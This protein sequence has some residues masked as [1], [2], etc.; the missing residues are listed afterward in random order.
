MIGEPAPC[1]G[2]QVRLDVVA[3][4]PITTLDAREERLRDQVR[5]VVADLGPEEPRDARPVPGHELLAGG[6]VTATPG[7]EKLEVGPHTRI[8]GA[9]RDLVDE[10]LQ[11]KVKATLFGGDHAPKLGRLVLLDRIGSGAMG[12]VFAAYDPRLDRKVAV[13]IVRTGGPEANSRVIAEARALGK[14][15]HPNVV[16]IHDA[17]E[18]DDAI[19]IVMELAP[20]VSLRTWCSSGRDWRDVVRVLGEAAAGIAAAHRAGLIHRDIKPDNI[21]VG[22]DRTRVVDFGLAHDRAGG[23]D[24]T[25]AG[26]PS[27]MAPEQL[28]D[29]PATEASDQFAFGVTLF[30][31][32]YGVRPHGGATRDELRLTARSAY[33]ARPSDAARSARAARTSGATVDGA[34]ATAPAN[35][36]PAPI[37]D[38]PSER[39]RATTPAPPTDGSARAV[40]SS[41]PSWINDLVVRALSPAPSDRFPSMD[42]L[43]SALGRDRRRQRMITLGAV[44]ALAGAAIGVGAYRSQAGGDPCTGG[45]ERRAVVWNPPTAAAVR[46]ALGDAPWSARAFATLEARATSWEGSYRRVCEAS[47]VT[48]AQSDTLLD[49]RMRCLDRALDRLGALST[50]IA[51]PLDSATPSTTLP[52]TT[53]TDHA[54]P[55]PTNGAA[56]STPSSLTLTAATRVDAVSAIHELPDP[57]ACESL[58]DAA[59]LAL[60]TDPAK[61]ARVTEA[62]REIDRAWAAYA[63]GRYQAA[64]TQVLAIE[65]RTADLEA[66]P[67]RAAILLLGA[68]VE[69]RIGAPVAARERLDRALTAAAAAHTPAIELDVW[70]RLLRHE[71]FVGNAGRV[72]E[73]DAFAHAAAA[74]AGRDGGELDGIVGEAH[75]DAGQ[76]DAARKRL[77]RAL[78]S[79]DPLRDDQR[80]LIEMNVGSLELAAGD[81]GAAETALTRAFDL[82]RG[83]LGDGHPTLALYLDKLASVD[84]ARGRIRAALARHDESLALRTAAYGAE[85]R[86]IATSLLQRSRTRIE[87]GQLA[88]AREDLE[89]ARR[90]RAEAYGKA[91]QRLGEIDAARG[92]AA[93]AA[94]D[95]VTARTE[96]DQATTLDP[97]LELAARRRAAGADIPLGQLPTTLDP[98][99]IDR[100]GALAVRVAALPVADAGPLAAALLVRWQ[101]LGAAGHP[102]LALAIA[103]ALAS[104]GNTG[105]ASAMLEAAL[106]GLGDEPSWTRLRLLR[107]LGRTTDAT[108]VAA[109]LPELR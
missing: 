21:L 80:A 99:S 31:A 62:E 86:S 8:V 3:F 10:L 59:E 1:D 61:R 76:L 44:A 109:Q 50:A 88:K 85:D 101:R 26:T 14:L 90:I 39:R 98:F 11:A 37:V 89:T 56:P 6:A 48:G 87:G 54:A 52:A 24:T 66:P 70:A 47:R 27:Y 75:R 78:A 53:A 23:E 95:L 74:R 102:A 32:L 4:D 18:I 77:Q 73:W 91:S 5:T 58:H 65:Q 46:T 19:Y 33:K 104:I 105:A 94:G 28:D 51:T 22:D 55:S 67:L 49:L 63:L 93:L 17:D 69:G 84:R 64:R 42:A 13:K 100:A 30:E 9:V 92:D 68:S 29:E 45:A 81:L 82:A 16:A 40:R 71:L 83:A 20:G 2:E 96:Y 103:P 25:S 79:K 60:P 107:A 97:S 15:A 12:T 36:E 57:I 38:P 41:P 106:V 43:T 34:A 35:G 72:I 108:S 7:V